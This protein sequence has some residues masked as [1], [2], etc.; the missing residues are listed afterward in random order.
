MVEQLLSQLWMLGDILL[1]AVLGFIIGI[2]RKFRNKEAGM[3]THTVLCLGAALLMVVSKYG[4]GAG[5]DT[6]RVAAQIVSGVGFLG[7]GIIV[8]RR[9]EVRGLTTAA[10][11]WASA[12][13]GMAC[14]ARLYWLAIGATLLMLGVQCFL[15]LKIKPFDLK[16]TFDVHIRFQQ[17]DNSNLTVK[18]IF[19]V[20][21]FNQLH[22][23]R[24]GEELWYTA[25]LQT[26]E[27]F[28]SSQLDEI[29]KQYPFIRSIERVENN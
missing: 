21:R 24:V 23:E 20:T 25:V 7:A 1:A 16:K 19:G 27:E 13:I 29:M 4:F 3:R 26:D 5:D 17:T 9:Q 12:G 10:G 14:G 6:A 15:H 22:L 2:E 28:T 11:V 18:Q 8:Y